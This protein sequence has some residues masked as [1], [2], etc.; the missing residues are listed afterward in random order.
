MA[1]ASRLE[2][3]SEE[4]SDHD[5]ARQVAKLWPHRK[6]ESVALTSF[7][8]MMGIHYW[9][10]LSLRELCGDKAIHHCF[11]CSKVRIDGVV[12]DV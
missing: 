12:Y 4:G 10:A 3:K 7:F 5:L 8:C 6:H 1:V 9:R 2:Q 11:W